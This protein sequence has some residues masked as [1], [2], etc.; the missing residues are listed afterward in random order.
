MKRDQQLCLKSGLAAVAERSKP[1]EI[2]RK[3]ATDCDG[4]R[5]L[6]KAKKSR[7]FES[8][9]LRQSDSDI[10]PKQIDPGIYDSFVETPAMLR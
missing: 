3:L 10:P 6:A 8:L 5:K 2:L 4:L 1:I 9:S 7:G